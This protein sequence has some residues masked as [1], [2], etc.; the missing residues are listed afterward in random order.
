MVLGYVSKRWTQCM[1]EYYIE[2]D[3]L[4]H[5]KIGECWTIK[6]IRLLHNYCLNL[7]EIRNSFLHGGKTKQNCLLQ[8]DLLMRKI[9]TQYQHYRGHLP[10][11]CRSLF[12]LPI[13]Q[14]MEQGVTQITLWLQRTT[15]ILNKYDKEKGLQTNTSWILTEDSNQ[16][17]NV[18]WDQCQQMT[19]TTPSI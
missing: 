6:V 7:W 15:I 10:W 5:S 9:Q 19:T 17:I 8:Q 4:S 12:H 11:Q 1:E 13:D 14:R 3:Q 18:D 2:T 16:C